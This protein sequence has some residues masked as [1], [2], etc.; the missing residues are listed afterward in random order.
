MSPASPNG[1][2]EWKIAI[3]ALILQRL[4]EFGEM[5]GAPF[6]NVLRKVR[7]HLRTSPE[8]FGEALYQLPDM[9][10]QMRHAAVAPLVI[11]YAVYPEKRTVWLTRVWLLTLPESAS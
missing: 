9:P 5:V 6:A 4:R 10:G 8:D 3:S 7:R 1:R 11:A 2:S